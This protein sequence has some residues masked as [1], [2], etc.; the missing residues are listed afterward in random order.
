MADEAKTAADQ[1]AEIAKLL[2]D[3]QDRLD[4]VARAVRSLQERL[5]DDAGRTGR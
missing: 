5:S 2:Q 3:A 4:Q 1:V